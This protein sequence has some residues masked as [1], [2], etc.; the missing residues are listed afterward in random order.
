MNFTL[1]REHLGQI[2]RLDDL[3]IICLPDGVFHQG[4][5]LMLFN[6][7]D[8][9]TTLESKVP[10]TYRSSMPKSKTHLEVAP[11]TL[12]SIVFVGDNIA[13]LTVGV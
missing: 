7:T 10:F 4:D 6:N 3:A 8:K 9:F 5:I 1:T 13:V 2:V 11:R 12:I